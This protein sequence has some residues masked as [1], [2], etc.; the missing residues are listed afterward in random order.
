MLVAYEFDDRAL[1]VLHGFPVRLVAP[2]EQGNVWVKWLG[3]ITVQ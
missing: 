2:G 1:H 3:R